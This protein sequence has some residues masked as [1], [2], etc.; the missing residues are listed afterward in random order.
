MPRKAAQKKK[1]SLGRPRLAPSKKRSPSSWLAVSEEEKAILQAAADRCGE[2]LAVWARGVLLRE[3]FEVSQ[4]L[5]RA[6]EHAED[7]RRARSAEPQTESIRPG[8]HAHPPPR[9]QA[10]GDRDA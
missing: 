10:R 7:P 6:K 8:P 4:P 1:P 9:S 5:L 2:V 3:A